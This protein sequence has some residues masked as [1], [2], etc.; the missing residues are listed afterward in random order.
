[1]GFHPKK[2]PGLNFCRN[3]TSGTLSSSVHCT[4]NMRATGHS[5]LIFHAVVKSGLSNR[6]VTVTST[7]AG[8]AKQKRIVFAYSKQ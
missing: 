4:L 1:M 7:R 6:S 3:Y 2:D 5:Y 8:E